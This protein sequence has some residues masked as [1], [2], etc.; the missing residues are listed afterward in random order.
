MVKEKI[1]NET[2]TEKFKRIATLRTNRILN[3]LRLLGNCS[4]RS[5]YEFTE[6]DVKKIFRIIE[7][8]LKVIK[9]LFNKKNR[10]RIEL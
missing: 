5:S 3:D 4:N 7:N 2:K 1:E 8:E 10:R 6:E 9:T